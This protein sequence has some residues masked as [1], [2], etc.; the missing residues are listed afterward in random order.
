MKRFM[1]LL[2]VLTVTFALAGCQKEKGDYKAGMYYA[3]TSGNQSTFGVMFVNEDGKIEDMFID[4]VYL[5]A[6]ENGGVSWTS[7]GNPA[8]GYATTKMALDNGWGY[9]MFYAQYTASTTTPTEE[10]YK[11]WLKSNNKL[12][13]FEQV[14][15]IIDQVIELQDLPSKTADEYDAPAGAT[16]TVDSYYSVIEDLLEQARK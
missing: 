13:W 14:R 2:L 3:S 11:A 15:L 8:T 7:Y 10:G 6:S 4:S 9:H 5:K 12:E 1:A 16:I